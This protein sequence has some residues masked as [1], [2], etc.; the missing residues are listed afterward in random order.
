MCCWNKVCSAEKM[1]NS[2]MLHWAGKGGPSSVIRSSL[3][4][5]SNLLIF[6]QVASSVRINAKKMRLRRNLVGIRREKIPVRIPQDANRILNFIADQ[7]AC[8]FKHANE[9]F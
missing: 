3:P 1:D 2:E 5:R 4:G 7:A 9:T 6:C 8:K